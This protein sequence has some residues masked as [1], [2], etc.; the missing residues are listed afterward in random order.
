M[1][2]RAAFFNPRREK[3]ALASLAATG[4]GVGRKHEHR[5]HVGFV[6]VDL[7]ILQKND[8]RASK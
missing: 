1:A 4:P 6:R 5:I 3:Y 2:R 8:D 7:G